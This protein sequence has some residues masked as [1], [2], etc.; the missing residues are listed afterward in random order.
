MLFDV[1]NVPSEYENQRGAKIF[2]KYPHIRG[3]RRH[4]QPHGY[5]VTDGWSINYTIGS[6]VIQNRLSVSFIGFKEFSD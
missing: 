1:T 5:G 6:H 4:F 3:R 2:L